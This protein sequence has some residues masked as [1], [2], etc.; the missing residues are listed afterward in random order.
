[1]TSERE[2]EEKVDALTHCATRLRYKEVATKRLYT[3]LQ[4]KSK[5]QQ[6]EA[7]LAIFRHNI[8]IST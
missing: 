5:W 4:Y 7:L 8:R 1:V 6:Q 3:D 2:E